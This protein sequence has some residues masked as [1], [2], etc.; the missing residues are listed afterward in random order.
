MVTL[1]LWLIKLA[2]PIKMKKINILILSVLLLTSSF[3]TAQDGCVTMEG[4]AKDE[5]GVYLPGVEIFFTDVSDD[6][7]IKTVADENGFYKICIPYGFAKIRAVKEGFN[8]G[9]ASVV[10]S[11]KTL[12]PALKDITLTKGELRLFGR[13]RDWSS[14]DALKDVKVT[15][16]NKETG[17]EEKFLTSA[18]GDFVKELSNKLGDSITYEIVVEKKGYHTKRIIYTN[19]LDKYGKQIVNYAEDL[20]LYL[21]DVDTLAYTDGDETMAINEIYF[22]PDSYLLSNNAKRELDKIVALMNK[23]PSMEIEIGS[24]TDC[25]ENKWYNE[26]LSYKRAKSSRL[27]VRARLKSN[28]DRITG[29]GYG[30]TKLLNDCKC[31]IDLPDGCT[32]EQHR[33]NRR[34]EF[35]ILNMGEAT[36]D[37][38]IINNSPNSFN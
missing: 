29:K 21:D 28:K 9:V 36:N 33:K 24:H 1:F 19:T 10:V 2:N 3:V 25:E 7:I 17:E 35:R 15:L 6:E 4:H 26:W 23:Y 18:E 5:K 16:I 14:Y 32:A 13:V 38:K 27:Y 31:K 34:T 8:D 11:D 12:V 30:E 20:Y 37:V 22:K